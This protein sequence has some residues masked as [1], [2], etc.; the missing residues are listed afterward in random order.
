MPIRYLQEA[1][2]PDD[3]QENLERL[4]AEFPDWDFWWSPSFGVK[5]CAGRTGERGSIAHCLTPENVAEQV[6]QAGKR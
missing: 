5:Y 2:N 1:P 4:A 6:R 3:V